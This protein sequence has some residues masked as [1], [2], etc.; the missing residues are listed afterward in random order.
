[1]QD[2]GEAERFDRSIA[3]RSPRVAW[4]CYEGYAM[5]E[6]QSEERGL[7]TMYETRKVKKD[8]STRCGWTIGESERLTR[9]RKAS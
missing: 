6:R 3:A 5:A 9:A 8:G 1:V 4:G 7:T 2:P